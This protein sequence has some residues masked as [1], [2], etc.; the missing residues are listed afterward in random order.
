MGSPTPERDDLTTEPVTSR[1]LSLEELN[2]FNT[3]AL[4]AGLDPV[5]R[6]RAQQHAEASCFNC[7]YGSIPQHIALAV[8]HAKTQLEVSSLAQKMDT[9]TEKLDQLLSTVAAQ[10]GAAP[11]GN[12]PIAPATVAWACSPALHDLIHSLANRLILSPNVQSYTAV[13]MDNVWLSQSLF[14]SIKVSETSTPNVILLAQF[15]MQPAEWLEEHLPHHDHGI[16]DVVGTRVYNTCIRNAC[17]HAREKLHN[18]L[19]V[20]IYDVKTGEVL[21]VPVPNLKS[22]WYRLTVTHIQIAHRFSIAGQHA[23]ANSLWAN[24]DSPTWARM[25][26]LRCEAVR[27]YQIGRGSSSIWA[28]ADTLLNKLRLKGDDYTAAFLKV[29]YNQ[30]AEAFNFMNF[31]Q[32]LTVQC[33]FKLPSDEEV[34]AAIEPME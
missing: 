17:K 22:L 25:A 5:H 28:C 20:G 10:Q 7:V 33:N 1:T 16:Q 6:Q 9:I 12:A 11:Q 23:D 3:L 13:E 8:V 26:Y 18:L 19:L 4:N 15:E 14:S 29:V 21:D 31:F 30:D 2:L 32:D 24:T 27:I 34:E